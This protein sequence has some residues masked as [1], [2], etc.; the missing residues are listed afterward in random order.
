MIAD[1]LLAAWDMLPTSDAAGT[2]EAT[3]ATEGL[4]VWLAVDHTAARHVL[5]EIADGTDAPSVETKGMSMTVARHRVRSRESADYLDITCLDDAALD[6]FAVVA[7][8]LCNELEVASQDRRVSTVAETLSRWRWFWNVGGDS[9]SEQ[10]ALGLFAELWFL[11]Q[12]VGVSSQSV[13]AWTGADGARHD[14]QWPDLSIEVKAT[15]RRADGAV[16]HTIQHLDQLADPETGTL[17]LFSLRVVR[18]RLAGNTLPGQVERCSAQLRGLGAD[19][20][21]FL[22]KVSAR[23]YSPANHRLHSIAYRILEEHLY[24]VGAG[25]PRLTAESFTGGLPAGIGDVSYRL[26]M[27]ACEPWLRSSSAAEWRS[28][29]SGRQ[30]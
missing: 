30:A 6:T 21:A 4:G 17:Y 19:R 22:R 8:D 12:W 28:A 20:D 18:D 10:D 25:F 29:A 16:V 1:E 2:L 5:I 23:G 9:L 24:E 26:Q 15:S 3:E 27:A 7:A 13:D 11:D 14:F